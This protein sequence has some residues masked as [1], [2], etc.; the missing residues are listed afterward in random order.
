MISWMQKHNK[1]LVWTI[2]IATIAFIGAGFVGWG[3]YSFGS[4]AGNIAKV[5]NIE[6]SQNKLN[7]VYSSIYNQYNQAMQ[8]K[9][10]DKKAKELG[11]V[12]QAFAR[13]ATQA[14]ILNLAQELG[15]IVSDKEVV[16]RLQTIPS[17]QK[18]GVFNKEL[19][20]AYLKSQRMKAKTFESTLR[21]ELTIQ[22]T[23][24][25]LM[26]DAL[27]FEIEAISAAMNISDKLAYNVLTEDDV[28]FTAEE[29]KVKDF[30]EMQKENYKTPQMYELSIVWTDSKDANVTEEEI[31]A[32]YDANSF[33]YTNAEGKQLTF[34]EAKSQAT[35][36]LKLKK[37]KK[38]AQKA[39]I[40]F[41]KGTLTQNEKVTLP[42]GDLKLTKEIWDALQSKNVG[43]ILKPKTVADMYATVKIE[44]IT[45]PKVKTF[46]QAKEEV[47]KLYTIQAKKEAL[48]TL[49]QEKLKTFDQSDAIISDFV[50]LEQNVN[51]KPLNNQESLQFL[52]KLFTSTKEKGIISVM[53]KVVVYKI[54]EQKLVPTDA[55]E[56]ESVKQTVN[57]L[58]QNT[59][60]SNLIKMLD[61]KYPTETYVGGLTN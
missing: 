14:K 1:Y 51:L 41:K 12:K 56:T 38:S 36:D 59:F 25:L 32:Y 23:L 28:P 9:L 45:L 31:K 2:W 15:I 4:K 6:I 52:Q 48:F 29:A 43:D 27:P 8:G 26:V 44:N 16:D 13:L 37:T 53:D 3:S 39:Y 42:V 33:N 34:E 30:W 24:A 46:E 22:K 50:K 19:Y 20:E 40:A 35:N 5:G 61:A 57:K 47:T 54:L 49:A 7:L 18:D 21:E 17:F 10:D 55:N 60:E 11:I 58:K